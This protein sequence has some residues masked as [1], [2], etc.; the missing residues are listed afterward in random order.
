MKQNE[1][2]YQ[3]V[4]PHIHRRNSFEGAIISW[5]NYFIAGLSSTDKQYP[6]HL[7]CRLI[8]QCTLTLNL[9]CQSRII[10]DCRPKHNST[11]HLILIKFPLHLPALATSFTSRP[12]SDAPGQSTEPT[13]GILGLLPNITGA[14]PFIVPK[15]VAS[16][17]LT[18]PIFPAGIRMP[19]MSSADNATIAAKERTHALLNPAPAAPF[20]TIGKDQIGALKQLALIF[21][22]ATTPKKPKSLA[23]PP[24]S[25]SPSPR[26]SEPI[27]SSTQQLPRVRLPCRYN[28]PK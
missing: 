14:T 4:S 19:R 12:A 22:Q 2:D 25:P 6:M 15:P 10:H 24:Q 23:H 27:S 3:L 26:V 8:P 28:T 13:A 1:I 17:L 5:N 9:L 21:Q 18:P 7:W 16:A 11:V 20:G